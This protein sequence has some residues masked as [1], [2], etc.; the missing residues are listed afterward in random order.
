MDEGRLSVGGPD[1]EAKRGVG[2]RRVPQQIPGG[3]VRVSAAG[4]LASEGI[5]VLSESAAFWGLF[6]TGGVALGRLCVFL[7]RYQRWEVAAESFM[8]ESGKAWI[9]LLREDTLVSC[10]KAVFLSFFLHLIYINGEKNG[11]LISCVRHVLRFRKDIAWKYNLHVCF[12][13]E[14]QYCEELGINFKVI[15]D[16]HSI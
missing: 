6:I 10:L 1:G 11:I 7:P 8:D 9:F 3:E 12:S 16:M 2:A 5:S 13:P 15:I 4:W 14:I